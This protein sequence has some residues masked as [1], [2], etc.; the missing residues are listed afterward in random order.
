M[1]QTSQ[2]FDAIRKGDKE[3][4]R[5]MLAGE[6]KLVTSTTPDGATPAL[7]AVYTGHAELAAAL[8]DGR[9]PD[10]FEACA[11]GM[12]DRVGALLNGD[13]GLLNGY[14]ND[15]FTGLGLAVFFNHPE[16]AGMLLAA[17]AEVNRASRNR[18]QVAPLHSAVASGNL[19]LVELLLEHGATP[20]PVEFLG[21]TPLHSA[22]A[23]GKRAMVNRLLAAGADPSRRTKDGKTPAEIASQY[24]HAELAEELAAR[25]R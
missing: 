15:G 16:T 22:A 21:A 1:D 10:F 7:W 3:Q 14:S 9:E 6:P 18:L 25:A 5:A 17:G 12:A 2:F 11:L 24:G 4:I 23:Q 13:A 20:D 19:A 8:L